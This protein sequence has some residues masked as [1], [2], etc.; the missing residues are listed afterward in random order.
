MKVAIFLIA[1]V[2]FASATDSTSE[3][4][5]EINSHPVGKALL[6]SIKTS[7]EAGVSVQ[8]LSDLLHALHRRE[9]GHFAE[10][11]E[12]KARDL[13]AIDHSI[14]VLAAQIKTTEDSI[15]NTE[16]NIKR[17]T[18]QHKIATADLAASR[19]ELNKTRAELDEHNKV[20]AE[21]IAN[22]KADIVASKKAHSAV[23]EAISEVQKYQAAIATSLVQL[24]A[25]S[26]TGIQSFARLLSEMKEIIIKKSP[27]SSALVHELIVLCEAPANAGTKADRILALLKDLE[28]RISGNLSTE[29]NNLEDTENACAATR[30]RLIAKINTLGGKIDDLVERIKGLEEQLKTLNAQ[31]VE[32]KD[33]LKDFVKFH[34]SE[35]A[36]RVKVAAYYAAAI[37]NSAGI[38]AVMEKIVK[39]YDT[40]VL[41]NTSYVKGAATTGKGF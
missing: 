37:K 35:Q 18:N 10:L 24:A 14:K 36:K 7:T 2:A 40:N 29:K 16:A 28:A 9:A 17:K 39:A 38:V 33:N 1:L 32:L 27:E 41:D 11:K 30:G 19:I 4:L 13:G 12:D 3:L 34:K 5:S 31:L 25:E 8:E 20:C 26:Q 23:R 6:L 21:T 15:A 22:L